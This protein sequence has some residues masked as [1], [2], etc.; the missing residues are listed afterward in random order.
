MVTDQYSHIL[1][2]NRRENTQ[3]FEDAFFGKKETAQSGKK[4]EPLPQQNA[5]NTDS[6]NDD[7]L[8]KLMAN[9][10]MKELVVRLLKNME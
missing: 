7:I 6:D 10:E 9:P 4:Q 2:E 1:D 3:L 8:K 5:E